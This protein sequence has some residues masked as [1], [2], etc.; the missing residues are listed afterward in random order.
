VILASRQPKAAQQLAHELGCRQVQFDALYSITHDTLVVCDEE[1]VEIKGKPVVSGIHPG[2]LKAG[3]VVMDLTAQLQASPL[4]GEAKAR[5]CRV[6]TPRQLL[7][8]QVELQAR[9]LTG[10]DVPRE[11]LAQA[12]AEL[13]EEA[14]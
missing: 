8:E 7:L 9:L 3:M 1:R 5:G 4:L 11:V 2:Y 10:K 14:D 12:C 13:F 6:V